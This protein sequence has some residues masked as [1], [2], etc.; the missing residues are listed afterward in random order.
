MPADPDRLRR[1]APPARPFVAVA[2]SLDRREDQWHAGLAYRTDA[3]SAPRFLHLMW[4]RHLADQPL[5]HE[6]L[7]WEGRY[8][9]AEIPVL[10]ETAQALAHQCRRV[11]Q[12][13]RTHGQAVRYS[14]RHHLGRFDAQTGEYLPHQGERG[15]TCATC[16]LAV[17]RGVDVEL[18]DVASWPAREEDQAWID[19]VVD[20]LKSDDEEHARAVKADGLVARFRP[21]EVAGACLL[22]ALKVGYSEAVEAA[23]VVGRRY[24]ELVPVGVV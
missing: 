15:L 19:R 4:D 23:A 1:R 20:G 21:P 16:V 8:V 12:R 22:P 2:V 17:C 7:G 6:R 5:D 24:E 11:A 3:A 14:I 9:W 10:E 18:V 13:L